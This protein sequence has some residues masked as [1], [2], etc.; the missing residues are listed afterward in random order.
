MELGRHAAEHVSQTFTRPIKLEFEKVCCNRMNTQGN[1]TRHLSQEG[2][3]KCHLSSSLRVL[4]V[5][6]PVSTEVQLYLFP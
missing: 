2:P 5:T 4:N 6:K 3:L 1:M